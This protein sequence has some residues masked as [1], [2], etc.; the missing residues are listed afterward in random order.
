MQPEVGTILKYGDKVY[1]V[2]EL[3][4]VSRNRWVKNPPY[5]GSFQEVQVPAIAVLESH[6]RWAGWATD[7][8]YI[9][10]SYWKAMLTRGATVLPADWE[11][12]TE[13][14]EA[15][16]YRERKEL[17]EECLAYLPTDLFLRIAKE[18]S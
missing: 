16:K 4:T 5:H 10:T 9:Q 15:R 7:V 13:S 12:P 11:P 3:C 2:V 1:K 8:R 17:L 6:P 14:A 18:L